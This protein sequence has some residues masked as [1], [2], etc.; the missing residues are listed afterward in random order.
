M[1]VVMTGDGDFVEIQGTAE[2]APFSSVQL[3]EMLEL[4]RVGCEVMR[5]TQDSAL[6]QI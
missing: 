5:Q 1:N 4:A 3:D 6:G 2:S